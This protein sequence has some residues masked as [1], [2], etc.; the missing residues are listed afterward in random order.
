[1][2][3][4]RNKHSES[5]T[6]VIQNVM[7][8]AETGKNQSHFFTHTH[9]THIITHIYTLITTLTTIPISAMGGDDKWLVCP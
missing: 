9:A 8:E 5:S 6:K 3:D 1:M 4:W 2:Y 7:S